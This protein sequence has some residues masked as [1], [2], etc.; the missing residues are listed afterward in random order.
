MNLVRKLGFTNGNETFLQLVTDGM[1]MTPPNPNFIQARDSILLADLVNH[2]GANLGELWSAFAKRGLG[3]DASSP[4]S[5][6]TRGVVESFATPGQ[7]VVYPSSGGEEH[8]PAGGP[9]IP[10][11]Q[12]FQLANIGI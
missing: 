12:T 5:L 6:T 10:G 7:L 1:R 8:G 3:L 9:F 11:F 2:N 4:S